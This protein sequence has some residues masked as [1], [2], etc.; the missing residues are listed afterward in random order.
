MRFFSN[1]ILISCYKMCLKS[2]LAKKTLLIYLYLGLFFYIL[3]F[4]CRVHVFAKS[5]KNQ[6]NQVSHNN[7]ILV[8]NT[9]KLVRKKRITGKIT[10]I[11]F[12]KRE[13]SET[14]TRVSITVSH[15]LDGRNHQLQSHYTLCVP[16]HLPWNSDKCWENADITLIN[17][18]TA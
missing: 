9:G 16:A 4:V 8:N 13:R 3:T 15:L 17:Y 6:M 12:I 1:Y 14:V 7:I 11:L 5:I 18:V 10:N 2:Q